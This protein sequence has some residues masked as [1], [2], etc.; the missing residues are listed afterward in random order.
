MAEYLRVTYLGL[1]GCPGLALGQ[2]NYAFMSDMNFALQLAGPVQLTFQ[3]VYPVQACRYADQGVRVI[4][5]VVDGYGNPVDL[6]GASAKTIKFLKPDG[7][8]YDATAVFLSNGY[9]GRVLFT[10]T[11]LL[12][13]F[14]QAGAWW[15]Q[16]A[17]TVG[18]K[19]QHTQWGAFSVERN[20][21]NN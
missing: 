12:P 13:P 5:A 19:R 9:D 20:I 21:D 18:G 16:A 17:V 2:E 7:T 6:R 8:T 11:S 10:S 1:P 3:P 15:V 4:V 14:N